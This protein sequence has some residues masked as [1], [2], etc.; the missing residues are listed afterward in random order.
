MYE[1]SKYSTVVL[2]N[3][4]YRTVS[5]G[6]VV[7]LPRYWY[8]IPYSLCSVGHAGKASFEGTPLKTIHVVH[9]EMEASKGLRAGMFGAPH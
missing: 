3:K 4:N 6:T 8:L 1:Y 7:Q 5:T 9:R 2:I